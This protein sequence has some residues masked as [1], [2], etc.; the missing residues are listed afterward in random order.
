MAKMEDIKEVEEKVKNCRDIER[1]ADDKWRDSNNTE[2]H[3]KQH[4][5]Q[6]RKAGRTPWAIDEI[7]KMLSG[8]RKRKTVS[9]VEGKKSR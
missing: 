5:I 3:G 7:L 1:T 8:R 9:T 6:E 4:W 2:K